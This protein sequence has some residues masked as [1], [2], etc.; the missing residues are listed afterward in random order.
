MPCEKCGANRIISRQK[1]VCPVCE[2]IRILDIKKAVETRRQKAKENLLILSKEIDSTN[3]NH[4]FGSAIANRELAAREIIYLSTKRTYAVKEWLAYTYLLQN[5]RYSKKNGLSNFSKMLELSR[6]MV[7]L[8]NEIISLEQKLV[9]P[10]KYNDDELE[11]TEN[12]PL[13]F[14]PEEAYTDPDFSVT[15]SEFPEINIES[16]F[17]QEGLML[18]I[19]MVLLSQDISGT[20][21]RYYHSRILPS[22]SSASQAN[23]FV[24]ISFGLSTW[25]LKR[26]IELGVETRF[27]GVLLVYERDLPKIKQ[28]LVRRFNSEDVKWYFNSLMRGDHPDKTDLGSCIIVRDE[29]TNVFCLP[30]FS[31]LMLAYATMK[32]MKES[33]LGRAFNFKGQVVEDYLFR[34]VSCY[35]ISLS[36]PVTNEP[37]IRVKHPDLPM[38]IADVMGYNDEY[39]LVLESKFW[40]NPFLNELEKELAKFEEKVKYIQL[41]L[42]KFGLDEKLKVVP[43]FYTPYAPY[44]TWHQ[45]T[46]LPTAIALGMKL[47]EV[48]SVKHIELIGKIPELEELFELIKGPIP[49]PV[50]ASLL[51][52]SLEPNRYRLH[53]GVVLEFDEKEITTFIDLPVSQHGFFIYLDI[54]NEIFRDLKRE[55]VSPGDIIRMI[56]VNLNETW[57]MTQLLFFRKIVDKLEWESDPEKADPYKTI[58]SL[59]KYIEEAR[60]KR[61]K[62]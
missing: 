50:D 60:A 42:P 12:E 45:I 51:R 23:K 39:V 37:L 14:V 55:K 27:Q 25:G 36:H 29:Q 22:I 38:E 3:Y 15:L 8:H 10:V 58:I 40:N 2:K 44:P 61:I 52:G 19:W 54:T 26:N 28:N 24:E 18:P 16:I 43:I 34:Y 6:E 1:V 21:R 11:W 41:N 17:L 59:F 33:D 62:A 57:T 53:D 32:W 9:V 56:T 31:L 48:F 30:L 20:L 35:D 47:S 46:I 4:A 49:F 7:R 5:L 13:S